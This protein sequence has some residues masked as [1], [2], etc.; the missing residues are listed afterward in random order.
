MPDV[1][2]SYSRRDKQFVERLNEALAGA[3]K[4]AWVDW[5]DIPASAEWLRE[6][7]DGIDA[8]DAFLFVLS[9]DSASSQV[10]GQELDH[11]IERR[12]RILPIVHR[13]VDPAEVR[14]EAAAINWVYL[15]DQD[16]FE[17]G[18]KTLVQALDTDLEHVRTHTRLAGEAIEWERSGQDRARLL[19]GSELEDAERWLTE[20][21]AKEPGPTELQAQFVQASREAARRRGR[22]LFGGVA[23]ALVVAIALAVVA[24]IQRS[25]AIH[26]S[27]VAYSRQL[28]A[29]AQTQYTRDP[30]LGVLLAM[31]AAHVSPS[32]DTR[33]ALRQALGESHIRNRYTDTK[34]PIGDAVWSPDGTR[35]LIS[36]ENA[37]RAEIVRPG[38][39]ARPIVLS[40]P[41]L[42][43]QIGWDGHGGLAITGGARTSIWNGR[44]GALVR[45]LPTRSV[46]AA[47]SPDG[48]TAATADQA[49]LL[50]LWSVQTGRQLAAR[51]PAKGHTTSCLLWSPDGSEVAECNIE[52]SLKQASTQTVVPET[53]TLFGASGRRLAAIHTP[54]LISDIA[55]SPNSRRMAISV[56][57][58]NEKAAGVRVIDPHNG[59]QVLSFPGAANAVAF[60]PDNSYLAYAN[61]RGNIGHVYTFKDGNDQPLVGSTGT[62]NSIAFNHT[63]SYVVT[64]SDDRTARVFDAFTG[65]PLEVLYGHGRAVEDASFNLDGSLLATASLDGTARV[66]TT[67]TPHAQAEHVLADN[68]QY[69]ALSPNGS[70][71]LV[72]GPKSPNALLLD[73]RTLAEKATLSPPAGEFFGGLGFSLD[74]RW[75][76]LLA[77]P[78]AGQTGIAP[79][80]LETYAVRTHRLA[81]TIKPG[82]P[83]EDAVFDRHGHVATIRR[84]GETDVWSAATGRRERVLLPDGNV[85]ESISYSPDGTRLTVSHPDGTIDVLNAS[86]GRVETLHG[87]KPVPVNPEEPASTIIIRTAFSPDGKWLVSFGADDNVQVWDLAT[88]HLVK[89][90]TGPET[91]VVS[92]AFSRDG[93]LLAASDSASAYLWHF[94]SGHPL[95]T[96]LRHADASTWGDLSLLLPYG[97]VRVAFSADGNTLTTTGDLVT[98]TWRVQNGQSVFNLPF[99]FSGAATPDAQRIVADDSGVLGVFRCDLCGGL[100]QLLDNAKHDVTRSLTGDERARYLRP[101]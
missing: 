101:N 58:G 85:A 69:V 52:L 26:Q 39:N 6:I 70:T 31:K 81:A 2:I 13:D 92:A 38:T 35:L 7:Q 86:G 46:A 71:A 75:M 29:D 80:D 21:A 54:N 27:Q 98:Q 28:D 94:P 82:A 84:G 34:G 88:G 93:N 96:P 53:V 79:A 49:G 72:A 57:V 8:S 40:T 73:S 55:F 23:F 78:A 77:G 9:P 63:A 17:Q 16:S 24:L 97:G 91:Q 83:I 33:E 32:S 11:A 66:W 4:D 19:R 64:S 56:I 22:I 89:T 37:D 62:I 20:A 18:L 45:R 12:K 41:G 14:S 61:S 74:G 100:S 36:D 99:A 67:P 5:E 42:D 10:C 1:F 43:T 60:S 59:R 68:Q 50:H 48:R 25:N 95:G 15:R 87:P 30:E 47:L 3:G 65:R 51:A 44:T 90:L 76:A